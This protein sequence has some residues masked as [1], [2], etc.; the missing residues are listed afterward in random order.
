M[1]VQA[2]INFNGNCREAVQFYSKVFQTN[3]PKFM[4]FGDINNGMELEQNDEIKKLVLHTN[5]TI[6]GSIVMFSDVPPDIPYVQGNNITLTVM[7]RDENEIRRYY[8]KLKEGGSIIMD[9][10]E[11]FWSKCYANL[12]DKY[13]IGWQLSL[14]SEHA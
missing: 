8:E 14:E 2:Y 12:I 4:L 7:S 11:T 13:G 10:Q 5:L 6:S 9:L 3:E 1:S